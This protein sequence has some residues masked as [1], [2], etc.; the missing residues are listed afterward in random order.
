MATGN[1]AIPCVHLKRHTGLETAGCPRFL[2]CF[3]RQHETRPPD[4]ISQGA[5]TRLP[6]NSA[7]LRK[8][9]DAR[10]GP[11]VGKGRCDRRVQ[12]F[13]ISRVCWRRRPLT[14]TEGVM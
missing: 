9:A 2:Y 12:D 5:K 4:L 1:T 7:S 6:C 14:R 13:E 8:V 10:Q 11:R 3:A